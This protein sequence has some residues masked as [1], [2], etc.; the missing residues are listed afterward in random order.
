MYGRQKEIK[1]GLLLLIKKNRDYID[2]NVRIFRQIHYVYMETNAN[3]YSKTDIFWI[4]HFLDSI[5]HKVYLASISVEQLQ[6]V[7]YGKINESLW[8]AFENNL[9]R[10]E[11]SDDEQLIVS[12]ALECFLFESR[13]FLDIHMAYICLLLKTGFSKGY[14][15]KTRFFEELGKV[16]QPPFMQKAEWVKRYFERNVFGVE[17]ADTSIIRKDWGRLLQ[18]LRDKIA[19]RDII[20]PSFDS[21]ETLINN[22]LLDWPTLKGMTYHLLSETIRNGMYLLLHDVSAYIYELKWDDTQR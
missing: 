22:I 1:D 11:C 17:E 12:F 18:S 4:N 20:N 6:A 14:M 7:R 13:S 8:S 10:L 2:E 16:N 21:N 3:Y 5:I 19:H 9:V 15:N